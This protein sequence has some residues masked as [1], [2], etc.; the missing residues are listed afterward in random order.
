MHN[1]PNKPLTG[2]SM[3]QNPENKGD[4]LQ[5]PESAGVMVLYWSFGEGHKPAAGGFCRYPKP[6]SIGRRAGR[7]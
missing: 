3:L 6:D 2:G 4:D 5:N 1:L 7:M